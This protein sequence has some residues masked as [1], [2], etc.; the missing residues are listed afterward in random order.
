[1]YKDLIEKFGDLEHVFDFRLGKAT[2]FKTGGNAD[3]LIYPDSVERFKALL[4][5]LKDA[6]H[7]VIGS[8]TNLLV[9]DK[10]YR[11]VVIS[12]KKLNKI[13][14]NGNILVCES[15]VKLSSAVRVAVENSLSGLEFA[16]DI[17]GTVGGL[18]AM[19]AGCYNKSCEDAVCYVVAENGVYNKAGCEFSYRRS[20]FLSGEAVFVA[21][22]KL[23][24]AEEEVIEYKLDR[25]KS[26]RRKTQPRGNSCGSVF[27]NEGYFAG[28]IIDQAGLKGA[29][30]GGAFVSEQ[31]ANFILS[32]GGCSQDIHD[33]ILHIKKKVYIETG[34]ELHEEVR[35]LGEFDEYRS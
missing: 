27:L 7:F 8:G 35:Y 28:K 24:N 21:A 18:V 31:H 22:F 13:K 33:L 29:R 17:P 15:G 5:Y 12:T 6:P 23:K 16:S 4:E 32:D 11:G 26:A 2:G 10:G 30:I 14:T 9:S 34:I 1:M 20:R 3:L 25:F 19:N